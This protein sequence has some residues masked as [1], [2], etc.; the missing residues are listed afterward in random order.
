M[1][2]HSNPAGG[3]QFFYAGSLQEC[4]TACVK[5]RYEQPSSEFMVCLARVRIL[6]F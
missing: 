1:T 4:A 3:E 6:V 2:A 5:L